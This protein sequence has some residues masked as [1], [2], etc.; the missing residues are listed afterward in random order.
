MNLRCSH[1]GNDKFYADLQKQILSCTRCRYY[2]DF[3]DLVR[4]ASVP[5][6]Q[7]ERQAYDPVKFEVSNG[8]LM[9]YRGSDQ[10]VTV[11]EGVN[12]IYKGAFRGNFT[13]RT[14]LLPEGVQR[15]E[16]QAFLGCRNLSYVRLPNSLLEI[17]EAAFCDCAVLSEIVLPRKLHMIGVEAF[18]G[19][20]SLVRITI[21]DSVRQLGEGGGWKGVFYR[22]DSLEE[23]DYP[24]N[25]FDLEKF[26]GSLYYRCH[27]EGQRRMVAAGICPSCDGNLGLFRRCK[28]CGLRW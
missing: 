22:C 20:R 8:I 4:D 12:V 23:I 16:D 2:Y 17:G 25:R 18:A 6:T 5:S 7:Y 26:R 27:P 1:C 11:P 24:K 21:P 10:V 15:I 3:A 9:K 13:V 19:C 28:S 14:V